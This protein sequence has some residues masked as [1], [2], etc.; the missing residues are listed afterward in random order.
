MYTTSP[1]DDCRS[2]MTVAASLGTAGGLSPARISRAESAR[3]PPIRTEAAF[4]ASSATT[5]SCPV[6]PAPDCLLL[7]TDFDDQ[8]D[9]YW[10]I[11]WQHCRANSAASM[12][13]RFAEHLQQQ[14]A[15]AVHDLG[16]AS[17]IRGTCHESGQLD[18]P[19][20]SGKPARGRGR[21]GQRVERAGTGQGS[22]LGGA[23]VRAD[24]PGRHQR[25]VNDW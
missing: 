8:L 6:R 3:L 13:A 19:P 21:C 25:A 15:C 11:Q 24:L 14:F 12:P 17:E 22:C 10:R 2:S 16:L 5:F 1:A 9:L 4:G 23:D 20:D 7:V 18:N